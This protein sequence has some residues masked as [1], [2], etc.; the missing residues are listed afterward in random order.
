L[1]TELKLLRPIADAARQIDQVEVKTE[2]GGFPITV[3]PK[4]TIL[5]VGVNRLREAV[6]ELDKFL[7]SQTE[8][9]K[10]ANLC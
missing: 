1:Q 4:L 8:E 6:R 10:N 2:I 7:K 9:T 5:A 3:Q